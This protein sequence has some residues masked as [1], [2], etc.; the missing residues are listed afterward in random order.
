M[1][2]LV[3][4]ETFIAILEEGS[5]V[6]AAG[7]LHVT[8]STVT[9][10][11]Q[12]LERELGHQLVERSKAGATPTAAGL[13]VRRNIETML[14]LWVQARRDIDLPGV[15]RDVCTVGCH[16][17]AWVGC[18]D[19]LV[20]LIA[21]DDDPVAIT[22]RRGSPAELAEWQR[23]GLCDITVSYMPSLPP[24]HRV[25]ATRTEALVLV[26]T[27]PDAPVHFDPGYVLVEAGDDF[28]R[29]HTAA[30]ANA[31]IARV[32]FDAPDLGLDYIR[33]KG[34]S[35][36]LPMRIVAPLLENGELHELADAPQFDREIYL[37]A[38][39]DADQ[40]WAWLRA[41]SQNFETVVAASA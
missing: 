34:G 16:P 7:R 1:V 18:A 15:V 12:T 11:L 29:N 32:T 28:V 33:R 6:G 9:A 3:G 14:D 36:Y 25:W 21:A 19:R 5:L 38:S 2:S 22:V 37:I 23:T 20:D 4:L 40:R 27:D 24:G 17:D 39:N 31:A 35:A 10:R 26:S 41:A 13:R 30:Y 8:Q